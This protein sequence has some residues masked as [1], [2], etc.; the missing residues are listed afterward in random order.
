M[1]VTVNGIAINY[2]VDG[3][4]DGPWV[5]FGNSLLTDLSIWDEQVNALGDRFR[6]LRYDHR[7]HGDTDASSGRYSFDLLAADAVGLLDALS[8][9]RTHFVGISMGGTTGALLASRHPGRIRTLTMCD[10][11]PRSTPA[12]QALWQDRYEFARLKGVE[13]VVEPTLTSWFAADFLQASADLTFALRSMMAA[14]SLDGY[15]GCVAALQNYDLR[16]TIDE[17]ALP[18]LLLA[19][20]NDGN[21][22]AVLSELSTRLPDATFAVVSDAGHI[23]NVEGSA[24]FTALLAEFLDQHT[25]QHRKEREGNDSPPSTGVAR[26]PRHRS[27]SSADQRETQAVHPTAGTTR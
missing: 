13:P 5:T 25:D 18:M 8:I 16:S 21:A 6:I 2:R 7:G 22:P 27:H 14:T 15:L 10:C 26:G 3:I 4:S 20:S 23:S 12:S 1:K 9:E 24:Q 11:R 19:G 17:L